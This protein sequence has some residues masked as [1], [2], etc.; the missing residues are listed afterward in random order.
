MGNIGGF[1][2]SIIVSSYSLLAVA[3]YFL[4]AWQTFGEAL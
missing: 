4:F 2:A 3:K 1:S